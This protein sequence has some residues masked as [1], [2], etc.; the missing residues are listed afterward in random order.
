MTNT[1]IQNKYI[2]NLESDRLLLRNIQF[3]D[4]EF[5]INLWMNPDV[6]KY[7]GGPRERQQML[8][9][10]NEILEDPFSDEYDLWSLI[11][12]SSNQP[13]GHC[14]LL[15]KEVEGK[16]EIEVIYVIDKLY[17]GK[18]YATEVSKMLIAY[19]FNNKNLNRVIALIKPENKGSEVVAIKNGMHLEKEIVRQNNIKM[20]LYVKE[21]S[22][23]IQ[24]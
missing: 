1:S 9:A 6:T 23:I 7:M 3:S 22:R 15:M 4:K 19:A 21:R 13:V 17:W 5:I 24:K 20:Y 10:V 18:G 11:E 14:G 16:K 12:K 8:I 2:I